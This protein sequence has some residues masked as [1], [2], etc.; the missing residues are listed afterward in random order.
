MLEI[1][2]SRWPR[3]VRLRMVPFINSQSNSRT[4]FG[5]SA[6]FSSSLLTRTWVR[7]RSF[8]PVSRSVVFQRAEV[9][10]SATVLRHPKLPAAHF[11]LY[12]SFEISTYLRYNDIEN[13]HTHPLETVCI[14]VDNCQTGSSTT[15]DH[16]LDRNRT[17]TVPSRGCY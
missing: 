9:D 2:R 11:L 17:F 10:S 6:L 3:A 1:S 13:S 16:I 12:F 8:V 15:G 14:S 4:K 7:C 5:K